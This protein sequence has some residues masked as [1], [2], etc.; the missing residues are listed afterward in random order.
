MLIIV[1]LYFNLAETVRML[2][3]QRLVVLFANRESVWFAIANGGPV[4]SAI[5]NGAI[6][7]VRYR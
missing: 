5:A 1:V 2:F 3:C 7:L 6:C 4:W